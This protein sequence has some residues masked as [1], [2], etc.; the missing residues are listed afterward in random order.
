M[1]K[2]L[3]LLAILLLSLTLICSCSNTAND[4]WDTANYTESTSVGEGSTTFTVKVEA[5]EKSIILT[6]STDE[7]NL[8][9]ALYSLGIINDPSFFNTVNGMVADWDKDNAYWALYIGE[10]YAMTGADEII[11]TT[12]AEYRL[13]YTK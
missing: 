8:G 13:V 10:E 5:G 11:P 6:V 3:I 2:Y 4:V 7:A 1:K 9:A 12:G